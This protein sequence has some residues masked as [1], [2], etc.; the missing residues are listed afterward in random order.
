MATEWATR[1][2]V[3]GMAGHRKATLRW[4]GPCQAFHRTH[5]HPFGEETCHALDTERA[6]RREAL[7]AGPAIR[8]IPKSTSIGATR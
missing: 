8:K 2:R 1:P 7:A 6:S 3:T 5:R 4:C